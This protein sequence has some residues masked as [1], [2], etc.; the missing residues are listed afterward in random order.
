MTVRFMV[1]ARVITVRFMVMTR[2]FVSQVRFYFC[3][4]G[5]C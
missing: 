4:K 5:Y 2:V 3:V 1:V